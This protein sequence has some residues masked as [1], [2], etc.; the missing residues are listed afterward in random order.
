MAEIYPGGAYGLAFSARTSKEL[1]PRTD[2]PIKR[3]AQRH[4]FGGTDAIAA[5][6]LGF[7]FVRQQTQI[8]CQGQS[9]VGPQFNSQS[10]SENR[11]HG[12]QNNRS[13]PKRDSLPEHEGGYHRRVR[14]DPS[15]NRGRGASPVRRERRRR[16]D[17]AHSSADT[18]A[19]RYLCA[20]DGW[21]DRKGSPGFDRSNRPNTP[22]SSSSFQYTRDQVQVPGVVKEFVG[23]LPSA[24]SFNGPF[25][26]TRDVPSKSLRGPGPVVPSGELLRVFRDV[27]I[28]NV[29]R[30]P[31]PVARSPSYPLRGKSRGR[32]PPDYGPYPGPS[33]VRR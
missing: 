23:A 3:F 18:G 25:T 6:D 12:H 24:S 26:L 32:P 5:R 31:G 27:R 28:Q 8:H 4:F 15:Y 21:V 16:R 20:G 9:C 22:P 10:R 17:S 30:A 2:Y 14:D 7:A 1:S 29:Q 19:D 13:L 11:E 33:G